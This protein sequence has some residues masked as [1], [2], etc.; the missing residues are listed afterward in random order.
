[1]Q[2]VE[3]V[4]AATADAAMADAADGLRLTP[5]AGPIASCCIGLAGGESTGYSMARPMVWD[6]LHKCCREGPL[7]MIPRAVQD[8]L[9]SVLEL[10]KFLTS[11]LDKCMQVSW[12][13]MVIM[14][15][16]SDG[17]WRLKLTLQEAHGLC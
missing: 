14:R 7:R 16:R 11:K 5:S 1:M 8:L 2:M 6:P 3:Q 4:K 10:G 17:C 15:L 13:Q 12:V 9:H